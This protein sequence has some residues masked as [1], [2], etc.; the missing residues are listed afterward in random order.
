MFILDFNEKRLIN[1]NVF[2]G[3]PLYFESDMGPL[4]S[5]LVLYY[6]IKARNVSRIPKTFP[7]DTWV[8]CRTETLPPLDL[9]PLSTF[10]TVLRLPS[11]RRTKIGSPLSTHYLSFLSL[12]EFSLKKIEQVTYVLKSIRQKERVYT[13]WMRTWKKLFGHQNRKS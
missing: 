8:P 6:C 11:P 13:S 12:F 2:E 9:S 10:P 5:I 1:Q 3:A 7:L 4:V